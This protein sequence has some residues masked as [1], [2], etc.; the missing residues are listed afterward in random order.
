MK[1]N[2]INVVTKVDLDAEFNAKLEILKE[3]V[4]ELRKCDE[5]ALA[6]RSEVKDLSNKF[7]ETFKDDK[8]KLGKVVS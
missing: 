7:V 2:K 1:E 3:K 4:N 6:I 5:K 8:A